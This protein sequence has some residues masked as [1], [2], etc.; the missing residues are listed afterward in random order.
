MGWDG[1]AYDGTSEV[2]ILIAHLL[3]GMTS[4]FGR[5]VVLVVH[6]ALPGNWATEVGWPGDV[7]DATRTQPVPGACPVITTLHYSLAPALHHHDPGRREG[8]GNVWLCP[9]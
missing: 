3:L 9:A 5:P 2:F 1:M 7:T 8:R 6:V 4:C